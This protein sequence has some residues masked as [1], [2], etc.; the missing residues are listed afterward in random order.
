MTDTPAGQLLRRPEVCARV[1]VS[2][3]TLY[4]LIASAGFPRPVAVGTQAVAWHASEV[5]EWIAA[6]P[7]AS[8]TR[9][10]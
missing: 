4:R 10:A 3:P 6:R 7:R 5:E 9:A 2:R 8:T 1:G